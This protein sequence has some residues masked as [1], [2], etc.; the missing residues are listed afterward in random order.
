MGSVVLQH[1]GYSWISLH[2]QA[3][4]LPPGSPSFYF[5]KGFFFFL[6]W[7]ILKVFIEFVQYYFCFMFYFFGCKAHG[8]LFPWPGIKQTC[9]PCIERWSPNL[10]TTRQVPTMRFQWPCQAHCEPRTRLQPLPAVSVQPIPV[11]SPC[12]SAEARVSASSIQCPHALAD[13]R[14]SLE[15]ARRWHRPPMQVLLCSVCCKLPVSLSLW[16][17][18]SVLTDHPTGERPSQAAGTFFVFHSPLPGA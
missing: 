2:W 1:V 10:W 4:S 12:L 8:I 14:L 6:V 5:F 11:F 18:F 13:V 15:S 3:D 7:I 17:S 9:T 16:N